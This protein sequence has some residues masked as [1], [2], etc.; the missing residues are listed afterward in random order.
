MVVSQSIVS[1]Q[2]VDFVRGEDDVPE[3][4]LLLELTLLTR[5]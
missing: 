4:A 5:D 1:W 3:F 2:E